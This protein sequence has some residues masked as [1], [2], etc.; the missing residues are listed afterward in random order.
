MLVY[1]KTKSGYIE[2]INTDGSY[3]PKG[4][5]RTRQAAEKKR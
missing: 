4:W 1:K 3:V 2:T 5:S